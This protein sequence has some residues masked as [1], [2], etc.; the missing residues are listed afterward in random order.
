MNLSNYTSE[1]KKNLRIAY[2]VMLGQLGHVLVGLADNLMVGKL[3]AAPLA[4]VS[5]A[6]GL[7]FVFLSLGIGFSFAITPL[8]AEADGEQD[9]KKGKTIFE[10]GIFITIILGFII[11]FMLLASQPAMHY[12]KQPNEVVELA[13]PYYQIIA[14]SMIPLMVFQGFKQFADGLSLTKYAMQA[15]I[16]AN[17]INVFFNY[18]LIYGKFGFPAMGVAGSAVGTLISR[19]IMVGF[20]IYIIRTRK[21]FTDFVTRF[22]FNN[23]KKSILKKIYKLGYPTALQ[24]WFEV[25]LFASGIFI[26]GILGTNSQA[27]NQI[28]LNLASMTFM[29]AV[30]LGV[31]ATVRVGNQK[32]LKN[33]KELRRIALSIFLLMI[34]IDLLF[35]FGFILFK[36][37]LPTYYVDNQEVI[38]TAATLIIIAGFFQLSD[39]IQVVVLGA[40]RGLQDVKIPMRITFIAYWVI[41]FPICYFLALHTDL[42]SKGIWIGLLIALTASAIMLYLRFNKLTQKLIIEKNELT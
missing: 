39:G 31:T 12:M 17:V 1:F 2:P 37:I 7:V 6:N 41:G 3:G 14:F 34:I 30:G 18:V 22:S 26:A 36:D 28:A 40:L 19:F 20:M 29:I 25:T 38:S 24:M 10:H 4:S 42:K 21:E 33:Y 16:L 15:T 32:G 23:I 13:K 11:C 35:A 9:K 8:I 5:L 27:A